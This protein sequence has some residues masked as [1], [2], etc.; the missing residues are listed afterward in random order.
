MTRGWF[1][2][3]NFTGGPEFISV[4]CVSNDTRPHITSLLCP[5]L[6]Q[7]KVRARWSHKHTDSRS[8]RGNVSAF[9]EANASPFLATKRESNAVLQK[10][11]C[12]STRYVS[13]RDTEVASQNLNVA[14]LDV[15]G[16]NPEKS[17][18]GSGRTALATV[19][20]EPA[21]MDAVFPAPAR[22]RLVSDA[23]WK[24]FFLR[25]NLHLQGAFAHLP[26]AQAALV[27]RV[28]LVL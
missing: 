3:L 13:K 17:D 14:G 4:S 26:T 11:N 20:S 16:V 12:R 23:T 27:I 9:I 7:E 22:S 24:N 18:V 21:A 25:R 5:P 8:V 2:G 6:A 10:I 19:A 28:S 15:S 1:R